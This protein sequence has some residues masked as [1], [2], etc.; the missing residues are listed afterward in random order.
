M[1]PAATLSGQI[2]IDANAD[3]VIDVGETGLS[4]VHVLLES[5][6]Q[7]MGDPIPRETWT[8]AQGEYSF[9]EIPPGPYSVKAEV[10]AGYFATTTTRV[11]LELS[12]GAEVEVNFGLRPLHKGWLPLILRQ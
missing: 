12:A 8:G 11:E 6:E 5:R 9:A 7:L 4:N 10:P 3:G 1:E 2:W